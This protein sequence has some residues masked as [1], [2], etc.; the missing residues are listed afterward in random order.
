MIFKS[1]KLKLNSIKCIFYHEFR[2]R[3]L[4]SLRISFESKINCINLHFILH[5]KYSIVNHQ[6]TLSL[7][8]CQSFLLLW[9]K[10]HLDFRKKN[11][12][13]VDDFFLLSPFTA[14]QITPSSTAIS[15]FDLDLDLDLMT[16]FFCF[17]TSKSVQSLDFIVVFDAC[18][19]FFDVVKFC[20]KLNITLRVIAHSNWYAACVAQ[21]Q[22]IF[23]DETSQY[24][25]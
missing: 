25:C 11:F 15:H 2:C 21:A 19:C 8:L 23:D 9:Y 6:Q 24:L 1:K 10:T 12:D 7:S 22:R 3:K 13:F 4:F 17:E 16:V 20:K 5:S 18:S 14:L